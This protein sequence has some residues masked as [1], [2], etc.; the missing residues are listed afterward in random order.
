[1][2]SLGLIEEFINTRMA[3]GDAIASVPD[4]TSWLTARDLVPGAATLS[5]AD[6]ARATSVRE[7]LRALIAANNADPVPSPRGDG[8]SPSAR[9]DLAALTERLPLIV[10]VDARP[11]GLVP[12]PGLP[13]VD[14]ALARMLATVVLAV[15]DGTWARLK[16]CR[17][18]SCRWAYYDQSRNRSRSWCSMDLCG[19]R[20]KARAFY[21][22][23]QP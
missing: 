5:G 1:M 3:D 8:L 21:N 23:S 2:A 11:P 20:A 6:V 10:D 15:A 14:S 7:G 13:A 17:E 18:P 16:A 19:N 9:D 4:L 22:R 12:R